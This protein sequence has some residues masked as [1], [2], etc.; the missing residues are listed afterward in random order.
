MIPRDAEERDMIAAEYVL[1]HLSEEQADALERALASDVD[2]SERVRAWEERFVP[3]ASLAAPVP[4][5][6]S[7]WR[8]IENAIHGALAPRPVGRARFVWFA[9]LWRSLG[10]WRLATAALAGFLLLTL[11]GAPDPPARKPAFVAVLQS[12]DAPDGPGWIIQVDA[13]RTVHSTPLR[14]TEL[15]SQR[16]LQLW[17]LVDPAKGPVA[18]GLLAPS[19][20]VRL[21]PERLPAI[22]AGQLFEIT[23][24]PA[25]GSPIGRPTGRILYIGRA[26]AVPS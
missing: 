21:P 17:T 1:G 14:R 5:H 22:D 19:A 6:P 20:A 4:P 12:R 18:L 2:L 16:V 26:A 15:D 9:A 11:L 8:G 10:L 23:L 3:A 24:E 7:L 13:D 25:E